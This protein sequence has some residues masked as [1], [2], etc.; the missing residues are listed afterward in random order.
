MFRLRFGE[1][2]KART[3]CPGVFSKETV[4]GEK[5]IWKLE[6]QT[7]FVFVLLRRQMGESHSLL[8]THL[9]G[10]EGKEQLLQRRY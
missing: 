6:M 5:H 9:T 3:L 1:R 2:Q 10:K 8:E 7:T 4:H